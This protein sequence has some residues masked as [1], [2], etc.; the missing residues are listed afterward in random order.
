MNL[1]E[2]ESNQLDDLYRDCLETNFSENIDAQLPY[3]Y[4]EIYAIAQEELSKHKNNHFFEPYDKLPPDIF[5]E[6]ASSQYLQVIL[7]Y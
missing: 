1:S 5:N 6:N 7:N 2:F 3:K 4:N